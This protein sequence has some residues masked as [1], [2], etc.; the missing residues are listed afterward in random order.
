MS[1]PGEDRLYCGMIRRILSPSEGR[2]RS[3]ESV[4]SSCPVLRQRKEKTLSHSIQDTHVPGTARKG[5]IL[6]TVC[7]R[8]WSSNLSCH[9]EP[10]TSCCDEGAG[11]GRELENP[12]EGGV[13]WCTNLRICARDFIALER[14]PGMAKTEERPAFKRFFPPS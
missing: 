4:G 6:P 1:F 12:T 14:P 3:M 10:K 7:R 13:N 11:E 5:S 2:D 9:G 8:R